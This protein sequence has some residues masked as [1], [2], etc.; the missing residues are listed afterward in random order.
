MATERAEE[1]LEAEVAEVDIIK[2][3]EVAEMAILS[4]INKMELISATQLAGM[5]K[6]N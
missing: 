2:M 5:N 3:V 6:M 1:G 4:Q